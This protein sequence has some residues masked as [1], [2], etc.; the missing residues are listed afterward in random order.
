MTDSGK[1][2]FSIIGEKKTIA[3][4]ILLAI[5]I[6]GICCA[7]MS[8]IW[9]DSKYRHIAVWLMGIFLGSTLIWI[10]GNFIYKRF[11]IKGLATVSSQEIDILI[12][13]NHLKYPI[14]SIS[15]LKIVFFGFEGDNFGYLYL[16]ALR[17]KDGSCNY[18]EFNEHNGIKHK[19]EIYLDN[20][21]K[22][23]MLLNQLRKDLT[24][25]EIED[26]SKRK[27]KKKL[28]EA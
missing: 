10:V 27:A 1:Y 22:F 15:N 20:E 6:T 14:Q 9:F 21:R 24:P 8:I 12:N 17:S 5:N 13:E 2:E 4:K 7:I 23:K 3:Y 11:T 25:F 28:V 26:I 19:Y 16:G 18:L